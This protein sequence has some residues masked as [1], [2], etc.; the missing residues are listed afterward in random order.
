MAYA[1][2]HQWYN[3]NWKVV[4]S[5]IGTFFVIGME[6]IFIQKRHAVNIFMYNQNDRFVF[7]F[8]QNS[9]KD[10]R[11]IGGSTNREVL[12][13]NDNLLSEYPLTLIS[14]KYGIIVSIGL[15]CIFSFL[16]LLIYE[17]ALRQKTEIGRLTSYV[18]LGILCVQMFGAV[19]SS[20][21]ILNRYF[22][23]LPFMISGG[24]FTIYNMILIGVM[25][26]VSR[27]EEIVRDWIKYKEGC[28]I[29]RRE[30]F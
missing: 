18:I 29:R 4:L 7:D 6:L 9:L 24:L 3:L 11:W 26:S 5:T 27:N 12:N 23:C 28:K 30:H 17:A 19:L 1:V 2:R 8:I 25:L 16:L 15:L 14:V 10:S 20:F 22:M 13:T 21:G